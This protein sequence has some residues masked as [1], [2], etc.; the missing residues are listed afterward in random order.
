MGQFILLPSPSSEPDGRTGVVVRFG[1]KRHLSYLSTAFLF[2]FLSLLGEAH[3]V[4]TMPPYS[5]SLAA[6]CRRAAVGGA[7]RGSLNCL[8]PEVA[9]PA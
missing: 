7:F 6:Q 3:E 9:P 5:P 8:A 2:N 4:M 1:M